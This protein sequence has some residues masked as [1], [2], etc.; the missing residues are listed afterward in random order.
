MISPA[1]LFGLYSLAALLAILAVILDARN[2]PRKSAGDAE[3]VVIH[4]NGLE[5]VELNATGARQVHLRDRP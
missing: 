3:Y 2:P 5:A 1:L 4:V